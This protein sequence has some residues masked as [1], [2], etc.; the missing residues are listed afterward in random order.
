MS[1]GTDERWRCLST[2]CNPVLNAVSAK[3]HK[4]TTGHRTA[5]WPVR[6]AAGKAKAKARNRNGYYNRY[7]VGAK[8]YDSRAASGHVPE[9][10]YAPHIFSDEALGQ[11]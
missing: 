11:D 9:R 4:E 1:D 7:N 8:S 10:E 3:A 2:G 5:K 6:S